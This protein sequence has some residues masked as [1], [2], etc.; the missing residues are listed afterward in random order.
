[1]VAART[2][3][4]S[5]FHPL[6][7]AFQ[8]RGVLSWDLPPRVVYRPGE[9]VRFTLTVQNPTAAAQS[10]VLNGRVFK[11]GQLVWAQDLLVDGQRVFSVP[12]ESQ[13]RMQGSFSSDSTD[14]VLMI[15][16]MDPLGTDLSSVRTE[17]VS[18]VPVLDLAPLMG[19][20]AMALMAG[21]ALSVS[22]AV[23]KGE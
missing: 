10:Y 5:H 18:D 9:T 22:S 6:H 8:Q 7:F 11:G 19:L 20:L 17:L 4:V 2:V 21:M 15:A 23:R 1:M 12:P 16:L 3:P 13:I 14:I